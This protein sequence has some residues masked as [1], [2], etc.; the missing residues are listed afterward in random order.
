VAV[1]TVLP[2]PP[3]GNGQLRPPS[4]DSGSRGWMET[5]LSWSSSP[6]GPARHNV[7]GTLHLGAPSFR[8]SRR[9][10]LPPPPSCREGAFA[11]AVSDL[12]SSAPPLATDG[13]R[14]AGAPPPLVGCG[15]V[16]RSGSS[17]TPGGSVAVATVLPAPTPGNGQLRTPS[18]DPSARGWMVTEPSWQGVPLPLVECT[19]ARSGPLATPGG[20]VAVATVLSAPN[21]GCGQLRPP[22]HLP[23]PVD[24]SSATAVY[25][26]ALLPAPPSGPARDSSRAANAPSP[27]DSLCVTCSSSSGRVETESPRSSSSAS[28]HPPPLPS[29]PMHRAA[30]SPSPS[31]LAARRP[32]G[33]EPGHGCAEAQ[34]MALKRKAQAQPASMRPRKRTCKPCA[35]RH[36][37]SSQRRSQPPAVSKAQSVVALRNRKRTVRT[38]LDLDRLNITQPSLKKRK[39]KNLRTTNTRTRTSNHNTR[40]TAPPKGLECLGANFPT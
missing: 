14:E 31:A 24:G 8:C 12:S 9:M 34:T 40:N 11:V 18:L 16:A 33:R 32:Y 30:A 37:S 29:P 35:Q 27:D 20:S 3:P 25:S 13:K 21:P 26:P 39:L 1:A 28:R 4:L 5:E 7:A 10:F 15:S 19:V 17:T 2:A 22:P 6:A 38:N 36:F 23:S